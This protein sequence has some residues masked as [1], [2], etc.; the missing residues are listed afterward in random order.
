MNNCRLCSGKI[1]NFKFITEMLN[2]AF[3][4]FFNVKLI[5]F[6]KYPKMPTLPFIS[7]D[8][9]TFDFCILCLLT[10]AKKQKLK[11]T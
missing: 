3:N 8:R 2:F 4:N 5:F 1:L 9:G 6:E 7:L 10:K 11:W